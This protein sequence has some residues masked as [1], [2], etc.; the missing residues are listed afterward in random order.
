MARKYTENFNDYRI[1][2]L[3]IAKREGSGKDTII[4][5]SF[6]VYGRRVIRHLVDKMRSDSELDKELGVIKT[7]Q[8]LVELNAVEILEASIKAGELY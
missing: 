6:T 2:A 7:D 1:Q 3:E 5:M 8:Y 4:P